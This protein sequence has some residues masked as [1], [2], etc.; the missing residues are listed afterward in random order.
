MKRSWLITLLLFAGAVM[1]AEL[2]DLR[3]GPIIDRASGFFTL[4]KRTANGGWSIPW[5]GLFI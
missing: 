3:T 4:K 2:S 1:A 5:A